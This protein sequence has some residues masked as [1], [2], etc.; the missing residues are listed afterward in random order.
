[1][2]LVGV[3]QALQG[4]EVER[5]SQNRRTDDVAEHHRQVALFGS[6][7]WRRRH[8]NGAGEVWRAED[9]VGGAQF[10]AIAERQAELAQIGIGQGRQYRRVDL[11][12]AKELDVFGQAYLL[13]PGRY[14][15]RGFLPETVSGLPPAMS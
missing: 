14:V 12:G 2:A 9:V 13:Q 8:R 6:G 5:R 1:L 11:L 3:D 4:F 7:A 15:D 10:L